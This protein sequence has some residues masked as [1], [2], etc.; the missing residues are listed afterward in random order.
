MNIKNCF[1]V[2][3]FT[4]MQQIK[5]KAFKISS[6]IILLGIFILVS[7]SNIIPAIM[8]KPNT[9]S[10]EAKE[11]SIN[12]LYYEDNTNLHVDISKSL[13]KIYPNLKVITSEKPKE[14]LIR[15]LEK[16]NESMVLIS[17]NKT[18]ASYSIELY[19]P[20]SSEAV[21]NKECDVL[22]SDISLLLKNEFLSN[23]G[24]SANEIAMV[25]TPF[26]THTYV[27]GENTSFES[28]VATT[29]LPTIICILLF[30]VIYFYGYWVANS[31]VAEK[32]SRV[33][34]LLL[35]STKPLELIVGKCV[36][37]GVLA[38]A[39]FISILI[40]ALVSFKVSELIV[41]KFID[42]SA[43]IFKI[44]S[45]FANISGMDILWIIIFFIFG[46]A[47]YSILN[48]LAGATVSKLEDLNI[49]IMPVSFISIIGFYLA[50]IGV[51]T[52]NS[53][54]SKIALYMPF[55]S[56]FYLPTIV[57]TENLAISK[58]LLSL[59]ILIATIIILIFFTSRVYSVVILQTGNR[60]TI[61]DL[62]NIFKKEK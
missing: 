51:S 59:A 50:I 39:Q 58:I 21:S 45:L 43:S 36:G 26:Q 35:T 16:T 52:P 55:S 23:N 29:L 48:A 56:P 62:F 1:N 5:G 27:A 47:L 38:I 25:N 61:S 14:E 10:T 22:L 40:V 41:I 19:K 13:N 44:S 57:L 33:M 7:L 53:I 32:T 12:T 11:F 24:L 46:Y 42:S 28:I 54:I 18:D 31:I 37:M 4:I 17:V 60:V 8:E 3:K 49:A 20:K 30:Y 9:A 2:F 15:D 34:E 6:T